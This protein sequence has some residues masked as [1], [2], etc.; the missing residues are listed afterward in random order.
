MDTVNQIHKEHDDRKRNKRL[1]T[2]QSYIE[3]LVKLIFGDDDHLTLDEF[4]DITETDNEIAGILRNFDVPWGFTFA[5]LFSI[6]DDDKDE[7][8]TKRELADG[9]FSLVGGSETSHFCLSQLNIS[10]SH[11]EIKELKRLVS[12]VAQTQ[13]LV[14]DHL[15]LKTSSILRSNAASQSTI[16]SVNVIDG[17]A[18]PP[19]PPP[20]PA[21]PHSPPA[22]SSATT[23]RDVSNLS[24]MSTA[25]LWEHCYS[26]IHRAT[27]QHC[28]NEVNQ[29]WRSL[30]VESDAEPKSGMMPSTAPEPGE[31]ASQEFFVIRNKLHNAVRLES[32]AELKKAID[33]AVTAGIDSG[34]LTLELTY[35]DMLKRSQPKE[36]PVSEVREAMGKGDWARALDMVVESALQHGADKHILANVINRSSLTSGSQNVSSQTGSIAATPPDQRVSHS[37]DGGPAEA[38]KVRRIPDLR[39][40][41]RSEKTSH[42]EEAK[43]ADGQ[44][45][46]LAMLHSEACKHS[47]QEMRSAWEALEYSPRKPQKQDG[48]DDKQQDRAGAKQLT[49]QSPFSQAEERYFI[50]NQM[51]SAVYQKSFSG[52][53]RVLN[54][55]F[56]VGL[57]AHSMDVEIAYRDALARYHTYHRGATFHIRLAVDALK[58]K[59]WY[60]ALDILI[61]M[62]LD[63]GV[64]RQSVLRALTKIFAETR[65]S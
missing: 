53:Q 22:T 4:L 20:L 43:E 41:F 64:D 36:V 42:E 23:V 6:I 33:H 28:K 9:L 44:G 24:D 49:K 10:K 25:D 12:K 29:A 19:W 5:D 63:R 8:V 47:N 38:G 56:L 55:A 13:Q 11:T 46:L 31:I 14:A 2:Q 7:Y 32:A 1:K 52:L 34:R 30:R 21:P 18:F 61:Q 62:S 57:D 15:G 16:A 60:L 59:D 17:S 65:A 39:T 27:E 58:R 51:F 48:Q 35:N 26:T 50:F 45:N 3:E 54:Q 37:K 40:K